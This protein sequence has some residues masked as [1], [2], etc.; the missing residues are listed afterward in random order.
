MC[1]HGDIT[2]EV[3]GVKLVVG[4][5]PYR[6][7]ICLGIQEGN[8]LSKLATFN[9]EYCAALFIEAMQNMWRVDDEMVPESVRKTLEEMKRDKN[10]TD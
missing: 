7:K 6:K 3:N 2:F 1:K 8:V 10:E 4:Y 5:F 9:N